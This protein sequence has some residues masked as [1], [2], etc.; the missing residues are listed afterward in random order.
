[1]SIKLSE[2]SKHDRGLPHQIDAWEYLQA[3][4]SERVLEE[5]A[6]RFRNQKNSIPKSG[7]VLIKEFEDFSPTAYY[8]PLT[9]GLP[10]TI[11]WGSTKDMNGKF[12]ML[13]FVAAV[14][15]YALTG[16]LFFGVI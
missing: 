16:H 14:V 13:G 6:K 8:D 15:S 9:G 3:N 12:A 2:A 4:T 11:G 7:V 1:M 5:F 10:I